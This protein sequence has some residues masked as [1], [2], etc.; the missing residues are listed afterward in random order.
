MNFSEGFSRASITAAFTA[1][2]GSDSYDV[3]TYF[4][5]TVNGPDS[6]SKEVGLNTNPVGID[7][8]GRIFPYVAATNSFS[9]TS[10]RTSLASMW[11][12]FLGS[13]WHIQ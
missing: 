12:W 6:A 10:P 3:I 5:Y 9:Q 7:A 1:T 8:G 4:H 11:A 13:A 2:I